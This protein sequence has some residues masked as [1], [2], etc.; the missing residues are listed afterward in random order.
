MTSHAY[1]EFDTPNVVLH[2]GCPRCEEHAERPWDTLDGHQFLRLMNLAIEYNF[3]GSLKRPQ[4]HNDRVAVENL[5]SVLKTLD[6]LGMIRD[7]GYKVYQSL[8]EMEGK[9]E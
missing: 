2:D 5:Y 9:E 6:R 4:T 3:G 7:V 8:E 1:H